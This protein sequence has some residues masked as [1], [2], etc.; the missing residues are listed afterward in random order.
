MEWQLNLKKGDFC[1]TVQGTLLSSGIEGTSPGSPDKALII[2]QGS[3]MGLAVEC[4]LGQEIEWD[5]IDQ[6]GYVVG[7]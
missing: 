4:C 5:A 2:L 1:I 7:D 3:G 6:V